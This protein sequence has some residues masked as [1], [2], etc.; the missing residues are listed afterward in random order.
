MTKVTTTI[1][2][3]N[4]ALRK[5]T[6]RVLKVSFDF[7]DQK[8]GEITT[9]VVPAVIP[10]Q[11]TTKSQTPDPEGQRVKYVFSKLAKKYKTKTNEWHYKSN[12]N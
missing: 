11:D 6:R 2:I 3:N 7:L 4:C 8:V 9:N 1:S 12:Q 10:I 5:A